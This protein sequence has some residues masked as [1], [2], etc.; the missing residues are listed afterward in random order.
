MSLNPNAVFAFRTGTVSTQPSLHAQ[1]KVQ[2]TE[3]GLLSSLNITAAAVVKATPG[4]IAKVAVIVAGAAG[5]VN[6]CAT[7][8]TAVAGNVIFEIPAVVGV[9]PLDW[10]CLVGIVVVPG[11]AQVVSVSY[12]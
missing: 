5:T 7:T 1:G 6:D 2:V 9:Y 4:R 11:A 8:G 12:T 3:G 10:P